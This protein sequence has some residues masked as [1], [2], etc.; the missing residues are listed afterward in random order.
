MPKKNNRVKRDVA[1]VMHIYCEGEKTEPNYLQKYIDA[2]GTSVG[3]RRD[4]VKIEPTTKNTPVELV[5]V[6]IKRKKS[7]LTPAG[8]VFWVV[9]DR[10]SVTKYPDASH[11]KA[12]ARADSN[13]VKIALSNVCFELWLLLHM[14]PNTAPFISYADLMA[15]SDFKKEL[16][17]RGVHDYEKGNADIFELLCRDIGDARA[18]A[19]AMNSATLSSAPKG[20]VAPHQLNPHCDI[21]LLLDAIDNFK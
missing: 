12:R 14:K 3:R 13:G 18:R 17:K 5:D 16:A 9:Y 7:P 19:L 20:I 1:P 2:L 6:A 10:E 8:D 4:V 11:A 15:R 21:P